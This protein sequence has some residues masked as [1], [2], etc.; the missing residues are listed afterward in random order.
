MLKRNAVLPTWYAHLSRLERW[1][2]RLQNITEEQ[3]ASIATMGENIH[4][5]CATATYLL[6]TEIKV[7]KASR[8]IMFFS[9]SVQAVT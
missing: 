9:S 2:A 5:S 3:S 8:D 6:H 1:D 4:F 7:T